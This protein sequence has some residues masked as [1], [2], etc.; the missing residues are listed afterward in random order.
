MGF[1]GDVWSGIKSAGSTVLGGIESAGETVAHGVG[2]VL[3]GKNPFDEKNQG[4]SNY[5]SWDEVPWYERAVLNVGSGLE[6]VGKK[7]GGMVGLED[8][9]SS[10]FTDTKNKMKS[11]IDQKG[12]SEGWDWN[13]FG[14]G[15][16]GYKIYDALANDHPNI[17]ESTGS[18]LDMGAGVSGGGENQMKVYG[19]GVNNQA[20]TPESGT[21][22]GKAL[23][24]ELD[25]ALQDENFNYNNF[26][27]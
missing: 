5:K 18:S 19:G 11:D 13:T 21:S 8:Y 17:S 22:L 1:F 14:K 9:V 15:Y 25:V 20:A 6:S 10:S 27:F 3:Q 23:A 16:G 7:V 12:S 24:V 2:N 4:P 26:N